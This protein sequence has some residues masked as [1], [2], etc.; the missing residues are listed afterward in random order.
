MEVARCYKLFTLL[1]INASTAHTAFIVCRYC[2][3]SFG[4][5]GYYVYT[6]NTDI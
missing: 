1:T 3:Y 5:K 2:S 6:Y 4:E